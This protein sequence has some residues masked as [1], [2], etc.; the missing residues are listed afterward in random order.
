LKFFVPLSLV[1]FL[2]GLIYTVVTIVVSTNVSDAGL[3][4]ILAGLWALSLGLIADQVANLRR[5]SRVVC[6][7]CPGNRIETTGALQQP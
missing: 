5:G 7:G 1:L 2:G 6:S 4:L 3:L